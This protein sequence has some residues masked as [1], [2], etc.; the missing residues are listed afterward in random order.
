MA[1]TQHPLSAPVKSP[2]KSSNVIS[3]KEYKERDTIATL[4]RLLE[5]A[6]AGEITGLIYTVSLSQ[7]DHAVGVTGR[8][9]EDPIS[10]LGAAGRVF[11]ILNQEARRLMKSDDL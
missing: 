11:D 7:W 6:R 4:E 3:I 5:K 9:R 1:I 10:G 8:Y 2:M